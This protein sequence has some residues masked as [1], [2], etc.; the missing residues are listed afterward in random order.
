MRQR[1]RAQRPVTIIPGSHGDRRRPAKEFDSRPSSNSITPVGGFELRCV[2][3]S[4]RDR[5]EQARGHPRL[6]PPLG[7]A[8][9]GRVLVR[10]LT[11]HDRHHVC[12]MPCPTLPQG[13][14]LRGS[15][16]TEMLRRRRRYDFVRI[17][18]ERLLFRDVPVVTRSTAS[19]AGCFQASRKVITKLSSWATSN[20]S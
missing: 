3:A 17:E 20:G 4:H 7:A 12:D 1:L 19:Y 16:R 5:V 11:G 8:R 18:T 14:W 10:H 2:S 15:H 6:R 13:G 9:T